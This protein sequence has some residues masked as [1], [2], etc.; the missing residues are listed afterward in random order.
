VGATFIR[1][2]Q[3]GCVEA[4]ISVVEGGHSILRI[5]PVALH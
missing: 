4:T 1:P 5:H 2:S 3:L